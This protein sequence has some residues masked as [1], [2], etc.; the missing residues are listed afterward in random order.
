MPPPGWGPP[1]GG[2]PGGPG[3][4]GCFGFLCDAAMFC[5]AAASLKGV[6]DEADQAVRGVR[7]VQVVSDHRMLTC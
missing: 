6:V 7:V 3:A 5:S 1:P 4:C 2:P